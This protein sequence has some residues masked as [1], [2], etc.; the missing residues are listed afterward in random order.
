M[1]KT[2]LLTR[3]WRISRLTFHLFKGVVIVAAR[4]G[5]ADRDLRVTTIQR[6]SQQMLLLLNFEVRVVGIPP[7]IYPANTLLVANHVSWIDIFVLNSIT[8]SRFVAKSEVRRWPVIGWLCV[9][10]GTLFI[11]RQKKRDTA[12]VGNIVSASLAEGDCIAMFPEGTTA[13]GT[14]LRPFNASLFQPI[15]ESQGRVQPVGLR[16]LYLDGQHAIAPAYTDNLSLLASI[17]RIVSAKQTVAELHF[18]RQLNAEGAHRR[19]LC[20]EAEAIIATAL[21]LPLL[22]KG[23]D[24]P[25]DPPAEAP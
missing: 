2:W 15:L 16:Y 25:V 9:K 10:T 21:N 6:W 7:G 1:S 12:R 3:I 18:C 23:A 13:D 14:Y 19:H 8:V 24:K 17:W 11:E 5:T 4:F 20:K 22:H